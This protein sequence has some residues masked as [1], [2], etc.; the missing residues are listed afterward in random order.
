[1][2]RYLLIYLFM[3]SALLGFSQDKVALPAD[4]AEAK[5][6]TSKE[7]MGGGVV[8]PSEK[9][10]TGFE[11]GPDFDFLYSEAGPLNLFERSSEIV[12][13]RDAFSK[14]YLNADGKVSAVVTAGP[15]HYLKNGL[16]HTILN[17]IKQNDTG[18]NSDYLYANTNNSH[19]TFYGSAPDK[20][21]RFEF[22]SKFFAFTNPRLVF[23]D[24]DK[25]EVGS[26]GLLNYSDVTV[27]ENV[28]TYNNIAPGIDLVVEQT[29]SGFRTNY[30]INSPVTNIPS[31]AKFIGISEQVN[32]PE[33]WVGENLN[34]WVK[35][36][37]TQGEGILK[38]GQ[39]KIFEKNNE[40]GTSADG[41][42]SLLENSST[43]FFFPVDWVMASGRNYPIVLDP[44][45][46]YFPDGNIYWTGTVEEDPGCDFGG[47]N[48]ANENI[49][50]GFDDGDFDNDQYHPYARFNITGIPDEACIQTSFVRF[51]QY[52]FN[53]P[54]NDDNFLRFY[55]Q[56]L[57]PPNFDPIVAPCQDIYNNI[58][59]TPFYAQYDVWGNCGGPCIDYNEVNNDWKGFWQNASARVQSLLVQNWVVFSLDNVEGH[60]D[61]LIDNNDEWLD[62]RGWANANRPQL[63]VYYD[64]PFIMGTPTT[65]VNN[66]CPGTSVDLSVAGGTTGTAGT[67]NWYTTT[68]GAGGTFIGSTSAILT[69]TAPA[70]T[71]TYYV[72]GEG[73]CGNTACQ[74]V[75]LNVLQLSVA[76]TSINVS[77]NPTCTGTSTTLSVVGGSLGSGAVW[78]WYT[79]G[80]GT[81]LIGT[82]S[83][84]NV[85]PTVT[86]TYF[87]RA[88]GS[89]NTT[90]CAQ[91][92]VNVSSNTVGGST[93][94]SAPTACINTTV[95]LNLTGQNGAV[96]N[97]EMNFNGGGWSSIGGAGNTS[98]TSPSLSAVGTYEFRAVVQNSPCVTQLSSVSSVTVV[99]ATVGGTAS[100]AIASNCLGSNTTVSLSG[101]TGAVLFWEFR[102]NGGGWSNIGNAGLTTIPT[103]V[104][105]TAGTWEYRAN[106]QNS[107]CG[108]QYS[109]I[110]LITVSAPS[111]GGAAASTGT[112]VCDGATPTI[113][114]SGQTGTVL[115]WERQVNGGGFN[116]IG[117]AGLN[118]FVSAPLTPGI[119]D[120]RAVVQNAPCVSA[121]ST[122]IT[123]IVSSIS[124]GGTAIATFSNLCEGAGTNVSLTGNNGAV[125]YWEQQINGGG[126]V[127]IGNAGS[128]IINTGALSAGSNEFRAVVQN[129]G[130]AVAFSVPALI[131]V[132]PTTVGG[133]VNS[134]FVSVCDGSP[135]TLTLSGNT[136]T[137]TNWERQFN[138]G[139]WINIGNAGVNPL[140]TG[141]LTPFGTYEFRALVTS[142]LCASAYAAPV[143][144]TVNQND[145]PSFNYSSSVFCQGGA[146]AS[147]TI[148]IG[149]GT[150]SASPAGLAINA[151]NGII[152]LSSSLPGTYTVTH[153][154]SGICAASASQ[155]VI[156]SASTAT[157]FSYGALSYCLNAG[158]NPVA[159]VTNPGGVFTTLN[160]GLIFANTATGE[161]DLS[162]SQPGSYFVQYSIGGS[163]PS[164]TI[165]TVILQPVGNSTFTYANSSYCLGSGTVTPVVAEFGGTFTA[166]GFGLVFANAATGAID[167][168]N[169]FP[170]TYTIT[171][172][173]A[174][175]CPTVSTQ[176]I[177]LNPPSD[178][179]FFYSNSTFCK[180]AANPTPFVSTPGGSFTSS[181]AGLLFTNPST[182]TI[183]LATSQPGN[184]TITYSTGGL[185]PASYSQNVVILE[186]E[187][188]TFAY[189]Q[190]SYCQNGVN[191]APAVS[192]LGGI[193]TASPA[194][195]VFANQFTGQ[196]NLAASAGGTYS[197][198]Y[199]VPGTCIGLYS[200]NITITAGAVASLSYPSNSFCS[201]GTDPAA[202]ISPI[203]G[204]FS[205]SPVGL[206]FA[207]AVGTI[208]V[209]A[210]VPG[211][212]A[213][214]YTAPGACATTSTVNVAIIS[215]PQAL[216]QPVANLCSNGSA[217]TLNGSPFGGTWSGGAYISS[218]GV[219]DPAV[220]GPGTFTVNYL[221]PGAGG[222]SATAS[223]QVTVNPSPAVNITPAG[224]FCSDA[225]LQVLT[226]SP[227][228]GTWS[229]NPFVS[230]NG[231]FFPN[232]AGAGVFPVVYTVNSGGCTGTAQASVQ[233]IAAPDPAINP[234]PPF[235]SNSAIQGLT[236]TPAGG[237]WSGGPYI[238]ANG[239][240]NPALASVG[241]NAVTYTV[242]SGICSADIT[243][244]ISVSGVPNVNI[245]TPAPLCQNDAPEFLI[246]NLPGGIFFGGSYVTGTGL[247]DPGQA[248]IG[249]NTVIYS[250]TGTNGCVGTDTVTVVVNSN[251]D[252]TITYPGT[253]C[254]DGTAITLSA[255]TAGGTWSGGAF[256]NNGVFDP[257]VAG[258]GSHEIFYNV[259]TGQ[260]CGASA[261]IFI[262]VEPKPVAF[263]DHQPNGLTV[264]FTDISQFADTYSWNFG[265][266][267]PEITTQ[268]PT[269]LF[270]DNGVY[271]VRLIAFN[272]CGS[273]T[274]IRNVAVNKAVGISENAENI[275]LSAF[276][277]PADYYVN[278]T[279]SSLEVGNWKLGVADIAG[280]EVM[281][282]MVYS[283]GGEFSKT[284]DVSALNPGVYFIRLINKQTVYTVKF[285]KM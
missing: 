5:I 114:V 161:I 242:S 41:Q 247:F 30:V 108:A 169:S 53:N 142:G 46:T 223:Y 172:T 134:N 204:T 9:Y 263:Y 113:S 254:E 155:T 224:P 135:V 262:T 176:V 212:Y 133:V 217:I 277:N 48:D 259:A 15:Q 275:N 201:N 229:G 237:T 198:T 65:S 215:A 7:R 79:G 163:C 175:P 54:R 89:C 100:P 228:G 150:F 238:A 248:A 191:P 68:C 31:S 266:G 211:A 126:W 245:L 1:M 78:N 162:L 225:N 268:S 257:S 24:A 121:T 186:N 125:L 146:N 274:L 197:V 32:I 246:T 82:G 210:S 181:P 106:V 178:P 283:G 52:N 69:I 279:A 153:T 47:D 139:G 232:D 264:Y 205:S 36:T 136:G 34:S 273:D 99:P 93:S 87:V 26:L 141:A 165:Q 57:D 72:R 118:S 144:V 116:N 272:D 203:G 74:S 255:A 258:V 152:D 120:F 261:S 13:F 97:W 214:S 184:Y 222:C 98:I 167:L 265:D 200:Q 84:I 94:I 105:N 4:G 282:E 250:I 103:G 208:D 227:L 85:S 182:G 166:S 240:F 66:V 33:N 23:L 92:T 21:I 158:S 253:V 25:N 20:G 37:D 81:T 62:F 122:S 160:P 119:Y 270:P 27:A 102:L 91:V 38:I 284:I 80:C 241:N 195:L 86:T 43:V 10:P 55:Y 256:I 76:A 22:E 177:T 104:L 63:L 216:I 17:T 95:G 123:V 179:L 132:D 267:S 70:T 64:M 252:A 77:Q 159:S 281:L 75:V 6:P 194:G 260:G 83:S 147:P 101:N 111:V 115:Y 234:A 249:N 59:S 174:G 193:F 285:V 49:R 207:D 39:I 164:S 50:V 45:V 130:C 183:S 73:A 40:N 192:Q 233:V 124:V 278:L 28:L 156:V 128:S 19:Q 221:V 151:T 44:Y 58:Q 218:S 251:P 149:G 42:I 56:Y 131:N 236:A 29:A 16:W 35:F 129:G 189:S 145:D 271:V 51:Y 202:T 190:N 213:V 112:L 88:E 12:D 185:C 188:A 187:D 137:I 90:A 11:L 171:Y 220:S 14:H 196:I 60:S 117:N 2:K 8:K 61:P 239:D 226:A 107:P 67:W 230:V 140:T 71:T 109:S 154:T 276:P 235:C 243:V 173:S 96:V 231:L 244:N 219:F 170:A 157:T 143:T 209:D 3:G 18:T 199:T 148:A 280:K 180:S 168:F 206:I 269:H 110:A 127:N 138:G